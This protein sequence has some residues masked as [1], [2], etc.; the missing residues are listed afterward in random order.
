MNCDADSTR[1]LVVTP[2]R[3]APPCVTTPGA[4]SYGEF[5]VYD[6]GFG[7]ILGEYTD[8]ELVGLKGKATYASDVDQTYG[9]VESWTLDGLC[10]TGSC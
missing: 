9:C 10:D 6:D 1:Y 3:I 5:H 2:I 8:A 4:D 7:C